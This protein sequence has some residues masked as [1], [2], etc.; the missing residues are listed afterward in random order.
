MDWD[1]DDVWDSIKDGCSNACD[2]V[3]KCA[4]DVADW[5]TG[6]DDRKEAVRISKQVRRRELDDI[7]RH[8]DYLDRKGREIARIKDELDKYRKA[9]VG[10]SI[11]FEKLAAHFSKWEVEGVRIKHFEVV[12]LY[13]KACGL[14]K[15]DFMQGT[16]WDGCSASEKFWA[17]AS[18]GFSL[19]TAAKKA[20]EDAK[21]YKSCVEL[22][23]EKRAVEREVLRDQVSALKN[24]QV[25]LCKMLEVY[26]RV[27]NEL[28]Y[29]VALLKCTRNFI[30]GHDAGDHFDVSLL[31]KRHLHAL[32][33]ADSATRIVFA[34]VSKTYVSVKDKHYLIRPRNVK[35]AEGI[36]RHFWDEV[37]EKWWAA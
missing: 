13:A 11:R 8:D 25:M 10:E 17:V 5:I 9:F 18:V 12:P 26:G 4:S 3:C 16:T 24:V 1:L 29:S 31:P 27:L 6:E 7:N 32:K 30:F 35:Q 28:D 15:V 20:C 34:M 23:I 19:G 22:D 2:G 21:T 14:S 37:G 33:A 36:Y